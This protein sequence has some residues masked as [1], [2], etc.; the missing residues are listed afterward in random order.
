MVTLSFYKVLIAFLCIENLR[1][2]PYFFFSSI[3]LTCV[4]M[5][6][7]LIV[8]FSNFLLM[9][10]SWIY[11]TES[12]TS[13]YFF[14]NLFLLFWFF[15]D[16]SSFSW[17]L[18][19]SSIDHFINDMEI[20]IWR[21]IG[22]KLISNAEYIK[23]RHILLA[24]SFDKSCIFNSFLIFSLFLVFRLFTDFDIFLFT[25]KTSFL[26]EHTWNCNKSCF[27]FH[28]AYLESLYHNFTEKH[29]L[30]VLITMV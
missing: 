12:C 7:W 30:G 24:S 1:S 2:V 16:F 8:D 9:I 5:F 17:F 29:R 20:Y 22:E 27:F 18:D 3:F 26:R 21:N 19:F 25:F 6:Y 23:W 15:L 4:L 13:Y 14:W 11:V 28:I 10:F